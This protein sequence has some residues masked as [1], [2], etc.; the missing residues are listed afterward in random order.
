MV[1]VLRRFVVAWVLGVARGGG[2]L[3]NPCLA[4][5]WSGYA[6]CDASLSID[7]RARDMTSR[8]NVSEKI[9][10]LDT[11]Q[12]A[13]ASLGLAAYDWWSEASSGVATDGHGGGLGGHTKFAYPITTAM[14]FNRS[15]WRETGAAIGREARALMNAGAA[16][17]TYWAPVVNLAREPRWG[18]NVEVPGE[19]PYLS[20]EYA[21]EF[22][23]GFEHAPED[24][25]GFLQASACCKHYVANEL[26]NTSEPDGEEED[27]QHVNSNVTLRDLVDSYMVPFQACVEKGKV[28]GLMCSY[29][30]VNGVPSC[31]NDW[32]LSTVARRAWRFDGYVTS[33]CDADA[34]VFDAHHYAATPE[35]AVRDVLAAGTDVDCQS[36]VGD[37]AAAALDKG[38]VDE[39]L[40]DDRLVNLFKVRL[41]LGH[42]DLSFDPSSPRGALD[43]IRAE[44]TVC[45]PAHVAA[46]MEGL[47]QSATLYK[48]DQG[49]L[50]F[51]A[52]VRKVLVVGPTANISKATAGYYG[53]GDVCG[54]D[55]WNVID[56]AGD[57]G[58]VET[59]FLPGVPS[60]ASS[61]VS[62][63]PAAAKA[64]EDADAV[65]VALGTDLSWAAEGHDATSIEVTDAQLALCAA[66]AAAARGP[67]V[68][69]T[70]TATPLDLS[71]I[72]AN[73]DVRAV[74][75]LGQPSVTVKG[76]GDLLYGRR[77]FA[78]R[79][80]QTVYPAAYEDQISIFDF[81]MRP[82]PSKFARPD[83]ET[84]EADCARGTNPGRTYRFYTGDAVVPFGFGLSYTTFAYA[85]ARA[86]AAAVDL[87]P[88]RAALLLANEA[89][90]GFLP[91]ADDAP[92]ATY[93]VN[94]T[95]TGTVDADDVVL[96]FLTPPNAGVDGVPL[97]ELF[98][99]DRV[100]VKA[101]ETK[102]VFLLPALRHFARVDEDGARVANPG[103]YTVEFGLP[104][105]RVAYAAR[106]LAAL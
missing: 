58:R 79:A 53:P 105:G 93:V 52:N 78:G 51:G 60:V 36:F 5:P 68:V 75:H 104:G 97:K 76:L 8:M 23:L 42:F 3:K 74:A 103:T 34:N 77:S 65:V 40:I 64:A 17:S 92:A 12:G 94:V 41:R 13:I 85:V 54:G 50:P 61:D 27:R 45:S 99:F 14:S 22:V 6:M 66:V 69:V 87:D 47:I 91:H 7:G 84:K 89:T 83:C 57:G 31:A 70:L 15:L 38:L 80:V 30:A 21:T 37:H 20:G 106:A 90:A 10:A 72:L 81:N 9:M 98:A 19:D 44:T 29:N 4:E 56:A 2:A 25:E 1:L 33:D 49:A 48:N 82:G 73:A 67:V 96:G 18:R 32:L 43:S 71:E 86:P 39:A 24:L 62:G 100:H 11:R 16:Y 26:E 35:E 28:S 102:Q 95:N 59:T 55:F 63:I 46:S 101:G 88:L